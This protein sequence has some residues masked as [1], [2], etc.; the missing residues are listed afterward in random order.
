M[1][2][3]DAVEWCREKQEKALTEQDAVNYRQLA[4]LYEQRSKQAQEKPQGL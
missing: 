2:K 4:E 1:L 3:R